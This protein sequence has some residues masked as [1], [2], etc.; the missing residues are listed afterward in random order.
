[1]PKGEVTVRALELQLRARRSQVSGGMSL[2]L[3]RAS[4]PQ[5]LAAV[6]RKEGSREAGAVGTWM[7]DYTA[8]DATAK[9]TEPEPS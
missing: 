2:G 8:G 9:E 4:T 5:L 7:P 1:M 3:L 6:R